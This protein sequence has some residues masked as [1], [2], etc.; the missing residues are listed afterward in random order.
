M[1]QDADPIE[2]LIQELTKFPGIGEKTAS[3]LVFHLLRC[4]KDD[5]EALARAV[6]NLKEKVR[7]C[8]VCFNLAVQEQCR[9]CQDKRRIESVI[10]VVEE[11]SDLIAI[12]KAGTFRGRYHVLQGALSPLDGIGPDNLKIRELLERLRQDRVDEVI[13]ATNPNTEGETTALYL[14]KLIK[15][16]GIKLTRIA[17]G[18]PSGG[19]LEYI[20]RVTIGKALDNRRE[21]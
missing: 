16:M 12:E 10:C 3:R 21:V 14:Q 8:S 1:N 15:P 6:I 20:D 17:C 9:I 2:L 5:A 13:L 18:V 19:D 4:P 7:F 11:P